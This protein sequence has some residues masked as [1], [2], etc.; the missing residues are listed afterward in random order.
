MVRRF[1]KSYELTPQIEL[2]IEGELESVAGQISAHKLEDGTKGVFIKSE[3]K[4]GT[5]S[6]LDPQLRALFLRKP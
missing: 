1:K 4:L 6:R 2:T 3:A 5:S